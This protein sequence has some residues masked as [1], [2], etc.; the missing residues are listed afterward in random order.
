MEDNTFVIHGRTINYE[1]KKIDIL[2]LD[3]F[4]DN[5]RINYIIS[6]YSPE[7]ITSKLIEDAFL[8][9]DYPKAL[10]NDI[11]SNG[12]LTD[13]VLVLD[14]KVIEGNTRFYCFR[15]LWNKTKDEK[16]RYIPAK[17]IIDKIE[18]RELFLLLNNYHIKG[19]K[20]WDAYEKAA[21][22]CKMLD[23]GYNIEE[24]AREVGS[25]VPKVENLRKA[26][27]TMRDKYLAR[28]EIR[29]KSPME[30]H[31]E[32]KKYSYFEAFFTDKSLTS[33][34]DTTPQFIDQFVEWVAEGRIPKAT[35]V[36]C[37]HEILGNKKAQKIF[38][39]DESSTAFK[40]AFNELN[41]DRPDKVNGFYK[42]V[43]DFRELIIN[44]NVQEIREQVAENPQCKHT[45]VF[46]RVMGD[47]FYQIA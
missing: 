47:C 44:A 27:Q 16:W 32:L 26:Y 43:A 10:L 5:P 20:S 29:S 35:D 2:E 28:D 8:S 6:K 11:S 7:K 31:E 42:K 25:T 13:E 19:K 23:Q 33:R 41:W 37:L 40:E 1:I 36:R 12:G 21:C 45:F 30:S 4:Y 46:A 14:G 9:L 22:I 15:R 18:E 24:V 38:K 34:A 17:V 3:Y 39:D